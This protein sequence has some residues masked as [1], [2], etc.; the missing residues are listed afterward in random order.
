MY[1]FKVIPML[2]AAFS[3][4]LYTA[5]CQV[6]DSPTEPV[7]DPELSVSATSLDFGIS[8]ITK[9][10]S[11]NNRGGSS[12]N[13]WIAV[14]RNWIVVMESSGSITSETETI[15]VTVNRQG[16][17]PGMHDGLITVNSNGGSRTI[18]VTMIV[19]DEE[20]VLSVYPTSLNFGENSQQLVINISNN[21]GGSLNWNITDNQPW[22]TISPVS[23][24][25]MAGVN[26]V[27]VTVS[28]DGMNAGTH[29]GLI[30]V[31]SNGGTQTVPV[32]MRNPEADL[33]RFW[34]YGFGDNSNIDSKWSCFDDDERSGDDYWGATE[35]AH[36]GDYA[37]WCTARG[38]HP[39]G[40]TAYR[41]R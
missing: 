23:G 11:M 6:E 15:T 32:Y 25:T 13:W 36:D 2:F 24:S 37:A 39:S 18:P 33:V 34:F 14:N 17:N 12:L 41:H 38:N 1:R 8:T 28:R 21:G 29:S 35:V 4:L 22:I 10:F 9:S 30:T 40:E 27:D 16:L 5:G 20:P 19:P 26:P 7:R 31:S 3:L